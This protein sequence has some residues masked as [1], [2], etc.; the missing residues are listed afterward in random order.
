MYKNKY[1][2]GKQITKRQSDRVSQKERKKEKKKERERERETKRERDKE[3]ETKINFL[4]SSK[5]N[6]RKLI[7]NYK[8]AKKQYQ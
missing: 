5:K 6:W 1:V 4:I 3:R 8:H 7:S 2:N